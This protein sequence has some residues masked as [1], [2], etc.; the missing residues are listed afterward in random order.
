MNCVE[1]ASRDIAHLRQTVG[2]DCLLASSLVE[3]EQLCV[4]MRAEQVHEFLDPIIRNRKYPNL[5][6][7]GVAQA[8]QK[9]CRTFFV[10]RDADGSFMSLGSKS[11]PPRGGSLKTLF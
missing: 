3:A 7:G 1:A 4:L 9:L 11:L 10:I 6:T 2:Q 8:L 5:G